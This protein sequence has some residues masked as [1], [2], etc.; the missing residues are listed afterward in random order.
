[1]LELDLN[2][3]TPDG[4]SALGAALVGKPHLQRLSLKENE[5]EDQ[6]AKHIARSLALC[7]EL[8]AL[9]F[10]QNQVGWGAA[11]PGRLQLYDVASLV[12]MS[13]HHWSMCSGMLMLSSCLLVR[14]LDKL[15]IILNVMYK[16]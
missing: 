14:C 2:E 13:R 7:N 9:D 5:L 10:C 6:G 12:E 1:M 15:D 8:V 16:L 11:V 4:A 3:I